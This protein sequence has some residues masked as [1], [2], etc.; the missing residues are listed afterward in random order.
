MAVP[1]PTLCPNVSSLSAYILVL[2]QV[3]TRCWAPKEEP[4]CA[5]LG[6]LLPWCLHVAGYRAG[7]AGIVV[8][9]T[10]EAWSE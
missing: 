5:F 9:V 2:A 4:L 1:Y 6:W 3:L 10:E 8:T 7:I